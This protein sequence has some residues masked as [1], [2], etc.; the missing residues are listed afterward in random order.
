M[1]LALTVWSIFNW[2][3]NLLTGFHYFILSLL[4]I[5]PRYKVHKNGVVVVTG[6]STGIGADAT[7]YLAEKGYIVYATVRKEADG[8]K[9]IA[10]AAAALPVKNEKWSAPKE[11]R[12]AGK[13]WIVPVIADVT[14]KDQLRAAAE[15]VAAYTEESGLPLVAL[16]NNAGI[17][18]GAQPM[19]DTSEESLRAVMEVNFFGAIYAT[20]AFL[21][22]LRKHQGRV[23]NVS[24]IA[25]VIAGPMMAVYAAS[26]R[27]LES[28]SESLRVELRP[29]NVSVSVI[30]PGAVATAIQ[31]KNA[32]SKVIPEISP[33]A[34]LYAAMATAFKHVE[35]GAIPARASTS[36]VM[37]HAI[38]SQYPRTR[39]IVG[40]DAVVLKTTRKWVSDRVFDS[41]LGAV[42]K[43]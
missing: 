33:Y 32:P 7:H 15:K 30:Q 29:F 14:N 8:Q 43:W 12:A 40:M 31:A 16:V 34:R 26:K 2:I 9:L 1:S 28:I 18:H 39:Y 21:P 27:A 36:Q 11:G 25:G 3:A 35:S 22:L 24:S 6:S 4:G 41:I 37:L 20:K 38:A 5:Y 10:D 23:V 17:G 19:E 13:G 42:F